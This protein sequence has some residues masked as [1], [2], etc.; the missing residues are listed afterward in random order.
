MTS[1]PPVRLIGGALMASVVVLAG[2]A[3]ALPRLVGPMDGSPAGF[4]STLVYLSAGSLLVLALAGPALAR[5]V[6]SAEDRAQ[7]T[8]VAMAL[9][10]GMAVVGIVPAGL[11]AE[12]VWVLAL[13][14]TGLVVILRVQSTVT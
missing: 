13:A 8:V 14:L 6:G 11:M 7:G 9:T 1:R 4:L 2:V 3:L 10:E 12:P 5:R